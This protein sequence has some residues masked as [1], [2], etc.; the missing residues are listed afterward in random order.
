LI[1]RIAKLTDAIVVST[2]VAALTL[3]LGAGIAAADE[4]A[5]AKP[6]PTEA[7]ANEAQPGATETTVA[8]AQVERLHAA[9]IGVM[10][11]ADALGYDGRFDE[12][13]PVVTET[14]DLP[15]MASKS[16]GRHWKS[17]DDADK[18]RWNEVFVRL[19]TAN[20]AGRFDA[21]SGEH[22][23]TL[24]EEEAI[25]N[26]RVVLTRLVIPSD[27]D[28]QLNYRL[29]EVNGQWRIIDI[30]LNGTVSELALRRSEYSAVLKREGFEELLSTLSEKVDE[31]GRG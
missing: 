18:E 8:T 21:F 19:I 20:Y 22:F 24:G 13:T 3:S 1:L 27:E 15:F 12:L 7:V 26:T 4:T 17:L 28:V 29:R 5:P 25:N 16:V 23:E 31:L 11:T 14:F 2:V 10:Q 9:L 30:Y 6:A